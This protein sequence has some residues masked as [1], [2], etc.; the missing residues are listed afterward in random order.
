M[1]GKELTAIF[2]N[3]SKMCPFF[4]GVY[5][6]DTLF[7]DG[8]R[9]INQNEKNILVANASESTTMGTHWLGL[10]FKAYGGLSYFVDIC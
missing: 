5:S 9:Y 2:T 10:L 3:D 1:S 6:M 7:M 4:R 8:E